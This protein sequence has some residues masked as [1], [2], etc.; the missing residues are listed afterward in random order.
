MGD[1][2]DVHTDVAFRK[3]VEAET[4]DVAKSGNK[5]RFAIVVTYR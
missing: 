1:S 3:A 2:R 5:F 4:H